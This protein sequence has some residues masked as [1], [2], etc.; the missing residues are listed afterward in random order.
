[1]WDKEDITGLAVKYRRP[2]ALATG[3]ALAKVFVQNVLA[4]AAGHVTAEGKPDTAAMMAGEIAQTA[5]I[6]TGLMFRKPRP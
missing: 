5:V 1:M 2:A 4:P 3:S 6:I